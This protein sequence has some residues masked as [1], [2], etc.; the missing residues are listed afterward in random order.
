MRHPAHKP[1]R[2]AGM[3]FFKDLKLATI[4]ASFVA[5]LV[6]FTRSVAIASIGPAFWAVVAG[7]IA[8]FGQQYR[9][10]PAPSID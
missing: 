10:R 9:Q 1:A 8:P 4:T 7:A 3:Q 6:G 2:V 5:A